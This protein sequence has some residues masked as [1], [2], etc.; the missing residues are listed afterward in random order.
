[1]L[2]PDLNRDRP[3]VTLRQ[4]VPSDLRRSLGSRTFGLVQAVELEALII[5]GKAC[6]LPLVE[7]EAG[8]GAF[9]LIV[10]TN[11]LDGRLFAVPYWASM[12]VRGW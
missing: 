5:R 9:L 10:P 2:V 3:D 11:S 7:V 8:Y 1:M 6:A 12:R 4:P